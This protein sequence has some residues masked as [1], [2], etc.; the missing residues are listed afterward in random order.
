MPQQVA[1]RFVVSIGAGERVAQHVPWAGVPGVSAAICASGLEWS[2][3]VLDGLTVDLKVSAQILGSGDGAKLTEKVIQETSHGTT[4]KGCYEP[5]T[6]ERGQ[7]VQIIFDMNNAFSWFSSKQIEIFTLDVP[8]KSHIELLPLLPLCDL[9]RHNGQPQEEESNVPPNLLEPTKCGE[10][11]PLGD[12]CNRLHALLDTWLGTVDGMSSKVQD[13]DS[14]W[15]KNLKKTVVAVR[16][17]CHGK[18]AEK[19]QDRLARQGLE[20]LALAE[21][22]HQAQKAKKAEAVASKKADA[23]RQADREAQRTAQAAAAAAAAVNAREEIQAATKA[24]VRAAATPMAADE[25]VL[26]PPGQVASSTP[27]SPLAPSQLPLTGHPTDKSSASNVILQLPT[28]QLQKEMSESPC[29]RE[30]L[31]EQ[32]LPSSDTVHSECLPLG[33]DYVA[34]KSAVSDASEV[35]IHDARADAAEASVK[36]L[37]KAME[38]VEEPIPVVPA[39]LLAKETAQEPTSGISEEKRKDRSPL[40]STLP[41]P[42]NA[43][44]TLPKDGKPQDMVPVPL[45]EAADDII[46]SF[47]ESQV[48]MDSAK[49]AHDGEKNGKGQQLQRGKGE[50]EQGGKCLST[51]EAED[52]RLVKAFIDRGGN[53]AALAERLLQQAAAAGIQVD[54]SNGDEEFVDAQ[55]TV[56]TPNSRKA[57]SPKLAPA[58]QSE[59]GAGDEEF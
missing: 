59:E 42:Q 20:A 35:S 4:F 1:R 56:A 12:L 43:E 37:L 58:M 11:E 3:V 36:K 18:S 2:V 47:L 45:V 7:V 24:A 30:L 9:P 17:Q 34:P 48:E 26:R 32:L 38:V 40:V 46:G 39:A 50:V 15:L 28:S 23:A 55:E 8:R 19:L 13:E 5:P 49:S 51:A 14:N 57:L 22:Q 6:D 54:H 53:V 31:P 25:C 41:T 29:R 44:Q 52:E 16:N 33:E 27:S 10:D 21:K